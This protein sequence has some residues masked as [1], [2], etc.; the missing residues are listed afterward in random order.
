MNREKIKAWL[1]ERQDGKLLD[2]SY[3]LVGITY[4]D[5]LTLINEVESE[6]KRLQREVLNAELRVAQEIFTTLFPQED[7]RHGWFYLM[8]SEVMECAEKWGV[9]LDW[10]GKDE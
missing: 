6:N 9:N 4:A 7:T 2:N 8:K 1:Y 3:N 5:I 10:E